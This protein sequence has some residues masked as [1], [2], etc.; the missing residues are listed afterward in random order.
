[1]TFTAVKRQPSA[2]TRLSHELAVMRGEPVHK[3]TTIEPSLRSFQRLVHERANRMCEFPHCRARSI[4]AHHVHR[5]GQGG[6]NDPS[7]GLALCVLHHDY[8][9]ANTDEAA[10]RGWIRRNYPR[11]GDWHFQGDSE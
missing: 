9:H 8:I 11:P 4:V 7:N 5:K 3:V 2:A 10:I 1:M 6:S